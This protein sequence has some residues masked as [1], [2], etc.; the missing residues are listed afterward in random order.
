MLNIFCFILR[1]L[2]DNN[3]VYNTFPKMV[4]P[5]SLLM[6]S[7]VL[8]SAAKVSHTKREEDVVGVYNVEEK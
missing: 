6:C 5:V 2:P 1:T 4:M 8:W 7:E 3:Y